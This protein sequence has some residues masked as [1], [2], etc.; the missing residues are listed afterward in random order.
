M[1]YPRLESSFDPTLQGAAGRGTPTPKV[2]A[3]LNAVAELNSEHEALCAL[4]ARCDPGEHTPDECRAHVVE[5]AER[6][7]LHMR[8]EEDVLHQALAQRRVL[9][10]AVETAKVEHRIIR[11]LLADLANVSPASRA[12]AA[13]LDVLAKQVRHH[14]E[15][16]A[17]QFFPRV[18]R[19]AIDL[20]ALGDQL[21]ARRE[22]LTRR[23]R[24]VTRPAPLRGN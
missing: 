24:P 11:R 6:L 21:R 9:E 12:F 8:L 3:R 5:I 23:T 17:Y 22:L 14:V 7:E 2:D 10:A 20:D 16:E 13:T 15:D 4:L 1:T 19:S 18:R